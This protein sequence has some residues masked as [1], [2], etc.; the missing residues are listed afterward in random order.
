MG[1]T[2]KLK[3]I[4]LGEGR[5][6][7]CIPVVGK[8]KEYFVKS[9][10][11]IIALAPDVAEWRMDHFEEIE[12]LQKARETACALRKV[13]KDTPLLCTFRTKAEGGERNITAEDYVKINRLM[14]ESGTAYA[15]DAELFFGKEGCDL[16]GFEVHEAVKEIIRTARRCGTAVV[17]SNHDF[18][19][20]PAKEEIVARLCMM[21]KTGMDA[22]KIAVM[23]LRETDV[24]VLLAATAEMKEKHPEIPVITM[25]MG[26]MGMVS[27]L[28]GEAFGSV[29]T[30]GM[31]GQAS[32]PGQIPADDLRKVLEIIHRYL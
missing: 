26:S 14:M 29:L 23:P 4:T 10:E 24:A 20:T 11:E 6:K 28:T 8:T 32:A 30:F 21:Q 13:L 31:A 19:K 1:Q 3:N 15:V 17:G 22:A 5:P 27:R 18:H 2:V 25:A 16:S 7:I 9:A 12:D